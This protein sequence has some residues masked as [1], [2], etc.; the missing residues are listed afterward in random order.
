[1]GRRPRIRPAAGWAAIVAVV[2]LAGLGRLVG[3]SAEPAVVAG[4]YTITIIGGSGSI[5]TQPL[6]LAPACSNGTD[7]DLDTKVDFP[8]DPECASAQDSNEG[9]ADTPYVAPTLRVAVDAA[10]DVSAPAS[11]VVWQDIWQR[12]DA[13]I[14]GIKDLRIQFKA[15]DVGGRSVT[16]HLDAAT[17]AVSLTWRF[18]IEVNTAGIA[19]TV[20]IGSPAAPL[21]AN[22]TTGGTGGTVF[23]PGTQTATLVDSAITFPAATCSGN[24]L[25][26]PTMASLASTRL[27][28]PTTPGQSTL[29]VTGRIDPN[30]IGD[31]GTP[32]PAPDLRITKAHD[33]D[34]TVGTAASYTLAVSN[35]GTAASSG[36]VVVGDMPPE[37]MTLLSGTGDGWA[38]L[39][40]ETGAIGCVS[41]AAIAPGAAAA[42]ITV[43]VMPDAVGTL[44][45][46]GVVTLATDTN[47]DNDTATDETV[48]KEA[49]GP[50]QPDLTLVKSHEGDFTVGVQGVYALV[51]SNVGAA[52]SSGDVVV[53]D[54]LPVGLGFV[55]GTGEGWGC[56]AAGQVVTCTSSA[57]I[58][59]AASAPSIALAV[60]PAGPGPVT[61]VA[62]VTGGGDTNDLDNGATD[63]TQVDSPP[64]PNLSVDVIAPA[65]TAG[66]ASTIAVKVAN[67]GSAP[68]TGPV[69]LTIPLPVAFGLT[70]A[71]GTGWSCSNAGAGES[72]V[73]IACVTQAKVTPGSTL[74]V[75]NLAVTPKSAGTFDV[76][77]KVTT[78]GDVSTS[79]DTKVV[80]VVVAE[81]ATAG[82]GDTA[83]EMPFT[84]GDA[85]RLVAAAAAAVCIGG[86]LVQASRRRTAPT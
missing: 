16:G 64:A 53:T 17:G 57:V 37:G 38:C 11:S 50:G 5:G 84:G 73:N 58:A 22:L 47:A 76:G 85:G 63:P 82:N 40:T 43:N 49:T 69:N 39:L 83:S 68:T 12:Q 10:G 21:T 60:M 65:M 56:A 46:T 31:G 74:P 25:L 75:V 1:M 80:Q 42:P 24:P 55:S 48:V 29:S 59:A 86:G 8:A 71:T 26:C 33:G 14:I 78:S 34:F 51:V 72:V 28:L 79:D 61:N 3:A 62:A 32:V 2:A 30:P 15:D 9:P 36:D 45:N 81:P 54:T 23:D 4:N 19:G 66:A 41:S 27:G 6:A 18:H 67:V 13:G 7:D 44:V 52:A 20:M 70:S 77:A 35:V